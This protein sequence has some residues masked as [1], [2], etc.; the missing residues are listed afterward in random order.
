[1]IEL[2]KAAVGRVIVGRGLA[3]TSATDDPVRAAERLQVSIRGSR[4]RKDLINVGKQYGFKLHTLLHA[5]R[6]LLLPTV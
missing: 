6:L 4:D 5:H 3:G 2:N 1:L